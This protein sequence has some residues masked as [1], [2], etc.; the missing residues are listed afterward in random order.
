MH[1]PMFQC[2]S[3]TLRL[4]FL[5]QSPKHID[6]SG[7][8]PFTLTIG[9]QMIWAGPYL[10]HAH[11]LTEVIHQLTLKVSVP[12]QLISFWVDHSGQ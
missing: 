3:S 4:L 1:E 11:Q 6:Q 5:G 12:D 2:G 10:L 8:E 7:V 9:L